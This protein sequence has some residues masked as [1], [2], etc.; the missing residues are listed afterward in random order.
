MTQIE[1]N[2]VGGWN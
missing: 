1:S 2:I